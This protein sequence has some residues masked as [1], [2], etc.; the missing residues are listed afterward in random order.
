MDLNS[1]IR[2][3]NN[4]IRS[5]R[6]PTKFLKDRHALSTTKK[7]RFFLAMSLLVACMG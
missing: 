4:Y 3:W 5:T 1:A 2:Q 7:F 6:N